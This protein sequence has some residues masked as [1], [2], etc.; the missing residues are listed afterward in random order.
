M[1]GGKLIWQIYLSFLLVTVLS[2]VAVGWYATHSLRPFYI[3]EM[4]AGLA[5]LAGVA[6]EHVRELMADSRESRIDLLAGRIG[7]AGGEKTRFTVVG[8]D[9]R[10]LADSDEDPNAMKNHAD[11]L[12]IQDALREGLGWSLRFSDTLNKNMM[13]VAVPVRHDGQVVAVVRAAVDATAIDGALADVYRRII[14]V[15]LAVALA[16]AGMSLLVSRRITRPIVAMEQAAR[17][18][19]AG[20]LDQRAPIPNT[21]ELAQLARTLNTMAQYLDERIRAV[22][23]QRNEVEAILTSMVEGVLA[24]DTQGRVVSVN[25][26]AAALLD[27]DPAAAQGRNIEE[28]VRNADLRDFV[29]RT[30]ADKGPVETDIAL[31][32]NGGRFFQVHGARLSDARGDAAG[33][34]IVLNDMTRIRRLENVR[35]D[36]VA[37]VSHELRTPVTSIQGFVEA[38]LDGGTRDPEQTG[39]YLSI[40]ARH[41]D[42]LNAIIED[43]LSLSRLEEEQQ[44][45]SIA[46]ETAPLRPVMES[47]VEM[48]APRAAD[49]NMRVELSCDETLGAKIN[50]PLLEQA[51]LNLLDNAIKYSDRGA[52]ISVSAARQAGEIAIAVKD[53]GC[54]IGCEHIERIFERFYVVDKSRSR[55]LGGTGLGL[56]IVKHIALAHGGRVTVASTPNVGSTFTLWLP[57]RQS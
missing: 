18:F 16:A 36:F 25:R 28:L 35:R 17:K 4:R 15:G 50:A 31:P 12:E 21:V 27:I 38:L 56:A 51:L 1:T 44:H 55:R 13:Y 5:T 49:K 37:N 52:G 22:T 48:A 3:N 23:Q 26:A 33:A 46:F 6:G 42:R 14:R 19:A 54:G 57:A 39:R 11:R 8:P 10:V 30:L 34:V 20:R 7:R 45:R 40:I 53:T 29:T 43:L 24:V 2:L 47:A 41:A 9:G 32:V